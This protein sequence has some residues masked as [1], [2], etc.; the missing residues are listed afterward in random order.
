MISKF[1]CTV[2]RTEITKENGA[3]PG[4]PACGFGWASPTLEKIQTIPYPAP[5]YPTYP[6]YP[7]DPWYKIDWIVTSDGTSTSTSI[8][9]G[10]EVKSS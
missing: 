10:E 4:C 3:Q 5:Y 6:T 7:G 1:T 2:C 9:Y 8:I